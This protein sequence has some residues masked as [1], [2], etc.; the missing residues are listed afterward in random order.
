[1]SKLA[2][3][4]SNLGFDPDEIRAKYEAERDKRLRDDGNQQYLEVKG[5][6]AHYTDDPYVERIERDALDQDTEVVI[7][8]GGFGGLLAGARFHQAG[9]TDI[10]IIEAGGDFGGTWYWN[11]YPGAQCDIESYCYL[12]LLEE[13]N[14]MP[15]EKYSYAP[16][17]YSH[18]QRIAEK[19]DLYD[20][21]I[22]QTRV[23]E[24]R[25]DE[26]LDRWLV[27]TDRED[28]IRARFVVMA[29]GPLN[30]PKLPAIPGLTEF[31]GHTFHTSR[32]DYDYTGGDHTGNLTGLK[33]KRVAVIGTGATTIQSV[34]YVAE[35]AE[36]LYLFQRTPSSVDLRGNK[37]TDEE[38]FDSL[39]P[40]WQRA[41]R[42]NFDA[43]VTGQP[44]EQDLVNDGWTEI[45]RLFA[46]MV[47]KPGEAEVSMDEMIE[48]VELADMRKMNGIR[49]RVD[50]I[51]GDQSI[52]EVLKPWYRQFCKRPTFNDEYLP[53][54]NRSNVSLI[55]TSESKGVEAI[56]P[57]G[58]VVGGVEY[59][60]DCI[61]YATGFEVGTAYT[62]RAGY[63]IIGQDGL[64]LTD[65]WSEGLK[66]FHGYSMNGFPNCFQVGLGQNGFSANLTA[67]LD[68]QAQHVAYLI[69]EIKQRGAR[70]AQ[71]SK[72]AES[73][74]VE[75][76]RGLAAVNIAFF[77]ACTPGYYNN[78]GKIASEGGGIQG[79]S[80]APGANAFNALLETWR[81]AGEL[82]GLELTH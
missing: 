18:S 32:W 48:L 80:Y 43:M 35:N 17:I 1:M 16:E 70:Y 3:E 27:S 39:K 13:L 23:T 34:P 5:E 60:V 15:K 61:I 33:G 78:E 19:F 57:N 8:G 24:L 22:F 59:E 29:T 64:T 45:F 14:Y 68:D 12:P 6:F 10:N 50:K 77:D 25:W 36:H 31:E 73:G 54:F 4:Y 71:P 26:T 56:T 42:Q 65:Y 72:E 75:T 51:V 76:I 82:E 67:V 38:W 20:G 2:K 40:G 21:A 30:R 44:V 74:W 55:D 46:S 52:A 37:P 41:R 63:E 7:I 49:E 66:T 28:T 58:V 62:R 69:N 9:I 11:R 81:E 47:P 53:T 79:E